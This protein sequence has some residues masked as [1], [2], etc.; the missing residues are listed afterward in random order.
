MSNDIR[1]ML[2][3]FTSSMQRNIIKRFKE[4]YPDI[5]IP[6]WYGRKGA[7]FTTSSITRTKSK[8]GKSGYFGDLPYYTGESFPIS[9]ALPADF[10]RSLFLFID[11]MYRNG[12]RGHSRSHKLDSFHDYQNFFHIVADM[13]ATHLKQYK[14]NT[15]FFGNIPHLGYDTIVYE[16]AKH[17]GIRTVLFTQSIFPNKYC[18]LGSVED[19]GV[20]DKELAKNFNQPFHVEKNSFPELFYMKS[21][22][23]EVEEAGK[24]NLKDIAFI[25]AYYLK[26]SPL[27]LLSPT[28]VKNIFSQASDIKRKFPKWR[29]PFKSFFHASHFDYFHTIAEFEKVEYDLQKKFVYFPLH[30]QPEM[31]TSALGG[32]HVD[33]ALAIEHLSLLLPDDWYIYVK[34]NPKQAGFMRDPLFFHRL[35]RIKNL[36][37]LPSYANS[38]ELTQACQFVA[39]ITGT[40]GWEALRNGKN[41]LTFGK[42]WYNSFVG[43]SNYHKNIQLTDIIYPFEHQQL[44][45]GVGYFM[46]KMADGIV[47]GGY[48]ENYPD[49]DKKVN[50]KAIAD[51]LYDILTGKQQPTFA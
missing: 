13:V 31:T 18:S 26:K 48:K 5:E 17:L 38:Q 35:Q 34:E 37:F 44:E 49:F 40:V 16:V 3:G 45:N 21:V 23:Q 27:S 36:V 39:T 46:A 15:V 4:D 6:L 51:Y 25:S 50:E 42:T 43:V 11:H 32:R 12:E 29:D 9:T 24:L 19:Y 20:L 1:L 14:I 30:L 47:D 2:V 22:K 10:Y 41:V 8:R 7:D 33:Q 28:K